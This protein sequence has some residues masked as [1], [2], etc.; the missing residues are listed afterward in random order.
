MAAGITSLILCALF[1]TFRI[2]FVAVGTRSPS[3]SLF[4]QILD[5]VEQRRQVSASEVFIFL[6]TA[7]AQQFP[8]PGQS[9]KFQTISQDGAKPD[10]Y[11]LKRPAGNVETV[12]VLCGVRFGRRFLLRFLIRAV[13]LV[14]FDSGVCRR[15]ISV[16]LYLLR[17]AVQVLFGESCARNLPRTGRRTAH[18]SALETHR[19]TNVVC[20]CCEVQTQPQTSCFC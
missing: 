12:F 7:L 5:V 18:H 6:K 9:L 17:I 4:A 3:F 19:H 16:G 10:V 14:V 13:V 2:L 15:W 11:E 8:A 1:R 20:Q